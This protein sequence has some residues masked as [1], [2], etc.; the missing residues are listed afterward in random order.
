MNVFPARTSIS[1]TTVSLRL[2]GDVE[3]SYPVDAFS[4]ELRTRL[5]EMGEVVL[6][7][8]PYA[9]QRRE[10][11]SPATVVA[12]QWL[13]D[14]SH[15][16]ANFAAG[17]LVL[18]EHDRTQLVEDQQIAVHLEPSDLHIFNPKTGMAISH[19]ARLVG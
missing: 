6:G 10:T 5:T 1:E 17:S 2:D 13:G 8:R 15:I 16:A 3:L 9:V 7:V 19:G 18:V 4:A 12:N 14:Q 11:G